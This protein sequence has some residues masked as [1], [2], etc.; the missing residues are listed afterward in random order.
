LRFALDAERR[1]VVNLASDAGRLRRS[2]DT[3]DVLD[4]FDGL[5]VVIESARAG[6]G[7]TV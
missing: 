1:H 6:V 5:E 3:R 2:G 4:D 7:V